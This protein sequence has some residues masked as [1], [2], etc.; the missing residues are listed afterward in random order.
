[1]QE[2][3]TYGEYVDDEGSCLFLTKYKLVRVTCPFKVVC[4]EAVGDLKVGDSVDVEEVLRGASNTIT[5]CIKDRYYPHS[6]FSYKPPT[7]LVITRLK[8]S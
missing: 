7:N 2:V 6:H 5:Y 4:I 1:M 3:S 8:R